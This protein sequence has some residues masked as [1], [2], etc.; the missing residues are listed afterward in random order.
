MYKPVREREKRERE[1]ALLERP[2]TFLKARENLCEISAMALA[3]YYVCSFCMIF[4]C[5]SHVASCEAC[6]EKLY[7]EI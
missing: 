4:L 3:C 1:E 6:E 7:R 2:A 5:T